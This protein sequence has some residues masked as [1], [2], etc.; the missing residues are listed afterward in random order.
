MAARGRELIAKDKAKRVSRQQQPLPQPIAAFAGTYQNDDLG[1]M[2]W[3][4]ER[5]EL[6]VRM[7]LLRSAVEI[8]DAVQNQFRVELNPGRGEV[9][10]FSIKEGEV[11]SLTY[12]GHTF[13]KVGL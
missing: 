2:A 3:H 5:G 9:I 12:A 13:N 6:K 4:L 7:G 10:Q 1:S 11:E 8:Y